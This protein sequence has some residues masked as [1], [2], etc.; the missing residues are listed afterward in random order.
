MAFV[1][2]I[3]IS[4]PVNTESISQGDDRIRELKRG[5]AEL[6]GVDH[7]STITGSQVNSTDSGCHNKT[8]FLAQASTPTA[9]SGLTDFKML[10]LLD[11]SGTLDLFITDED[12]NDWQLTSG[13]SFLLD[14]NIISND[15]PLVGSCDGSGTVDMIKV[16]TDNVVELATGA[17]LE[18]TNSP[19]TDTGITCKKYVDDI[20][21]TKQNV[22]TSYDSGWFA[23]TAATTYTKAHGLGQIPDIVQ[24][25]VGNASDG[26][27]SIELGGTGQD[28]YDRVIGVREMDATNIKLRCGSTSVREYYATNGVRAYSTSGYARIRAFVFP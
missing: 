24:V 25:W 7:E 12:N 11:N 14:N 19:T 27:G 1:D 17:V 28:G 9:P 5:I 4:T 2:P 6:L 20:A 8:T 16:N 15:T 13:N 23:V 3:V 18:D 22:V 26:T 10:Y 21:D